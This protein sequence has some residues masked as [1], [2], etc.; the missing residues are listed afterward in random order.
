MRPCA[1]RTHRV[2][3]VARQHPVAL[4]DGAVGA[5]HLLVGL[6]QEPCA[7]GE[8]LVRH[9]LT[10]NAGLAALHYGPLAARRPIPA[11]NGNVRD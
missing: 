5:E 1:R 8:L 6:L 4:G 9:G 3:A 11:C 10:A 2:L 7:G